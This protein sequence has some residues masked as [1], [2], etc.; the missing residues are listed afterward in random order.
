MAKE[1]YLDTKNGNEISESFLRGLK[2]KLYYAPKQR[3]MELLNFILRKRVQGK[4]I[5]FRRTTFGAD[6]ALKTL[7]KSEFE[8]V[9]IHSEKSQS[10]QNEALKKFK[11]GEANFLVTTD[12]SLAQLE[13]DRVE[14]VINFDLPAAPE[15]Y[16]DRQLLV[17]GKGISFTFCSIE[18]KQSVR[19]VE[20]LMDRRLVVEKNHPFNDDPKAFTEGVRR[21]SGSTRKG[22]KSAS[23]KQKKRRW[24]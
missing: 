10:E 22:R 14:M 9:C 15:S 8:A 17:T 23:S 16:L 4:V 6:K 24:Y 21:P 12:V 13:L 3:K 1:G 20:E 2:Q 5:V 11:S 7:L 19:A 18:E